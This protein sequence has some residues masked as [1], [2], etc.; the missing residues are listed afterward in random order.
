MLRIIDT[1]TV[2]SDAHWQ[3]RLVGLGVTVTGIFIAG[4]LI[5]LIANLFDQRLAQLRRGQSLVLEQDHVLILGWS[6]RV[7]TIVTELVEANRSRNRPAI[8][9]VADQDKT[10]MEE[11]LKRVCGNFF[12]T[13]IV[14][15]T[16]EPWT[17][18][19]LQMGNLQRARAVIVPA[20]AS[21]ATAIKTLLAINVHDELVCPVVVETIDPSTARTVANIMR[22]N[23]IPVC[24]ED[25]VAELTAQACREPGIGLVFKEFL[26]FEGAEIYIDH[27]PPLTGHTY[28]QACLAFTTCSVIGIQTPTGTVLNPPA[29]RILEPGAR[30]I[31]VAEDDSTFTLSP[32][33][34]TNRD[35]PCAPPHTPM[36]GDLAIIGWSHVGPRVISEID[37][38]AQPGTRIHVHV[39]PHTNAA[40]DVTIPHTTNSTVAVENLTGA[41]ETLATQVLASRPSHVILLGYRDCLDPDDADARTLLTVLAIRQADTATARTVIE[42]LDQRHAP[43]A[44]ATGADDFVVSDQLTSQMMTQ[45]A[46]QPALAG[47]FL[48][49]FKPAGASVQ[50]RSPAHFHLTPT[51]TF[52]DLVATGLA[53]GMT[54]I[55]LVHP[56]RDTVELNPNKTS[57]LRLFEDTQIVVLAGGL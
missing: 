9:I 43:L 2:A 31:A 45:L 6:P 32:A 47:V 7:P 29:E 48:E 44:Q 24:S 27:F 57:P 54:P 1:G 46:E 10:D 19:A 40:Q 21:D 34:G 20:G 52:A 37:H 17:D 14:C 26:N 8:V 15:R 41:P 11:T 25:I 51:S 4:T 53:H 55:G 38:V 23:I 49:L 18:P 5:G 36:S 50:L 56:D 12:N 16:A 22:P 39:H 30:L 28:A 35:L 42:I 3:A 13:R 33:H